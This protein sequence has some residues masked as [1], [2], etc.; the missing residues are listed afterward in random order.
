[1][2]AQSLTTSVGKLVDDGDFRGEY[3]ISGQFQR[4]SPDLLT[5]IKAVPGVRSTATQD[6]YPVL[7]GGTAET[8]GGLGGSFADVYPLKATAGTVSSI[9]PGTVIVDK[10]TAADKKWTVGSKID[11]TF[12]DGTKKS[13]TVAGIYTKTP[14]VDGLQANADEAGPV[15][16]VKGTSTAF[17]TRA[18]GTDT[19]TL[20]SGLEAV[21]ADNPLL[22]V[23][24]TDDLKQE[25]GGQINQLLYV[26]YGLLILSIIIAV[27]GVVNTMAMAVLERTREIGLLRA[28]GFTRR[29]SRRM[30]R[31]ESVLIALLGA[32]LGVVSGLLVGVALQQS[33]KESA[34]IT[35]LA[36]P[37]GT[38]VLFFVIAGIV[39]VVAALAP[40][41]RAARMDVLQAIA[42]D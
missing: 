12:P 25:I 4:V 14:F 11:T 40:A 28:I 5:R 29:Q 20:R 24:N 16:Q 1:V 2:F 19:K 3:A 7:V 17:V 18:E 38:I 31:R 39:G 26:V 15:A 27:L 37:Y 30:I 23:Q 6:R 8:L 13:F 41:R 9:A 34:G 42:T 36:I 33:T 21:T 32:L 35:T 10:D 22:R